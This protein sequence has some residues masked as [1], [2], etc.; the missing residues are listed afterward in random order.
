MSRR[1]PNGRRGF[2]L[3]ITLAM[4]ALLV[5]AV[6][7]LSALVRVNG[8]VASAGMAQMQAQQNALLA[9]SLALGELQEAAGPDSRVTGLGGVTSAV[10]GTNHPARYWCGVWNGSQVTWLAS[11]SANGAIP[12]LGTSDLAIVANGSLGAYASTNENDVVRVVKMPITAPSNDG[13]LE[14]VGAYAYWVG[15]EGTKLSAKLSDSETPKSG[16]KHELSAL[17]SD[18][19]P[20]TSLLSNVTHYEQLNLIS[21]VSAANRRG[22]FHQLTLTHRSVKIDGS[23]LLAGTMN[24]NSSSVRYWMA[25]GQ[26]YNRLKP[27]GD[28]ALISTKVNAT[29]F[30]G[31][32]SA[33]IKAA[34]PFRSV[35]E[36]FADAEIRKIVEDN[37][38]EWNS[39]R[40]TLEPWMV[41]RSDTFR[42]RSYGE[43]ADAADATKVEAAAYCEAIV[44][45]EAN[46][47]VESAS[48]SGRRFV[49]VKFRWLAPPNA[50]R[51]LESDI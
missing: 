9:L 29:S 38:A 26:T 6:Y 7:A 47:Q 5:L 1:L 32:M 3:V 24:V 34:G 48:S 39:F 2:A 21:G 15:D 8:Q 25:I 13:S 19:S 31:R 14:V 20:T 22:S 45:R 37:E 46:L 49:I 40:A 28:P 18:L 41:V 35:S 16:E 23:G 4:L 33:R 12:S 30:A 50:T 44:Q 43:V 17:I 11:G 42:I 27:G 51:P 36:F 10:S